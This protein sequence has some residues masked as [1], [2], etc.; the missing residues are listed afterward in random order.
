MNDKPAILV[1]LAVFLALATFPGWYTL[2]T[3]ALFSADASPP[4]LP[5]PAGA[6]KFS[7]AWSGDAAE[8]AGLRNAFAENGLEVLSPAAVLTEDTDGGKWRVFDGQRRYLV[9][10]DNEQ[11]AL[12]VYDG[13]VEE[14]DDMRANHM[15]VLIEWREGVIRHGDTSTVE[16]NGQAFAKS[17]TGTCLGC[18]TD[19]QAFCNACHSYVNTL[20]AWPARNT[21][22]PE[23][24]IRCWNCHLQPSEEA[25]DG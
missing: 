21:S 20:P 17:L 10:A 5:P 9:L 19:R 8:L 25:N 7:T 23:E 11:G 15:A 16:V 14:V 3:A 18:H 13:C 12:Q 4:D 2:G 22:I 24:G 6:L 1:G